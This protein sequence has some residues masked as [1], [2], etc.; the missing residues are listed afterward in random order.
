MSNMMS[1]VMTILH[2]QGQ[3]A[4]QPGK[5]QKPEKFLGPKPGTEKPNPRQPGPEKWKQ[6]LAGPDGKTL[7]SESTD[8]QPRVVEQQ[9]RDDL[10][11]EKDKR[12]TAETTCQR[13][14]SYIQD[15]EKRL[16]IAPEQAWSDGA[17]WRDDITE[18]ITTARHDRDQATQ[19]R[20]TAGD[21]WQR[22]LEPTPTSEVTEAE[23]D[24]FL[25]PR[26]EAS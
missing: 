9:L 15:L 12:L 26:P 10:K 20:Q 1:T 2:D 16:N 24:E 4:K 22:F 17:K 6:F 21:D 14:Y 13:L 25:G 23:T 8:Q 7:Y 3:P 11:A 18:F 5:Q 19:Q